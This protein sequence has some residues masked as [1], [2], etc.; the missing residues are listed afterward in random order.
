MSLF[1]KDTCTNIL[2]PCFEFV[3]FKTCYYGF[4]VFVF[5]NW[6]IDY[7]IFRAFFSKLMLCVKHNGRWAVYTG[8][9]LIQN[10]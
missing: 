8:V 9:C 5:F 3:L 4:F 2:Y 10:Q 6:L 1:C 7:L